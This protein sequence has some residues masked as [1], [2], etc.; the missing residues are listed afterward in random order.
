MI[1]FVH[2]VVVAFLVEHLGLVVLLILLVL[3]V[4]LVREVATFLLL[5]LT[6]I[7]VVLEIDLVTELLLVG[8]FWDKGA[9]LNLQSFLQSFCLVAGPRV[10]HLEL[11]DGLNQNL[12]APFRLD[13]VVVHV[14]ETVDN[15]L[16]ELDN[17]LLRH[18]IEAFLNYIIAVISLHDLMELLRVAEL[19]DDLILNM[20]WGPVDALLNELGAKLILRQIDEVTFDVLE[21]LFANLVVELFQNF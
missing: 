4:V 8:L 20:A 3:D 11:V 6:I 14:L 16:H 2:I 13:F 17:V 19:L 5:V 10:L 1:L 21:N 9:H 18:N 12:L 15:F 7:S